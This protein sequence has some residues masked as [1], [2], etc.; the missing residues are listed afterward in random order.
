MKVRT[1]RH[2]VTQRLGGYEGVLWTAIDEETYDGPEAPIG[3]GSTEQEAIADLK[4]EID[5]NGS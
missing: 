4:E 3:Y 2:L 5:A 1:T